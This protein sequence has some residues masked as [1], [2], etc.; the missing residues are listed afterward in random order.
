MLWK[1]DKKQD[2]KKL[3]V[4]PEEFKNVGASEQTGIASPKMLPKEYGVIKG[5]YISEK[6]SSL[7]PLNQ[8]VF[9]VF[10]DATKSEVKKQIE[11][12]FSVKVRGVKMI[13]LPRKKRS[14]GRRTGFKKG[15]KKAIIVL[16]KG[17]NIEQAKA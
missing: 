16:E 17:Y 13:N 1:K 9:K 6:S 7:A 2:K 4:A 8:Y 12:S 14:L 3:D 5:F 15:F 11:K 10:D